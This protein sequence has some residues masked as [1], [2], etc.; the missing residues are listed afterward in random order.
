M[1][2]GVYTKFPSGVCEIVPYFGSCV[3]TTGISEV[4]V[5]SFGVITV[6]VFGST[7]IKFFGSVITG[8]VG[9]TGGSKEVDGVG[10]PVGLEDGVAEFVGVGLAEGVVVGLEDGDALGVTLEVG[11]DEGVGVELLDEL[12]EGEALAL[13]L[14]FF[15]VATHLQGVGVGS[16]EILAIGTGV[17]VADLVGVGVGD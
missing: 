6:G 2:V 3:I 16:G 9:R 8:G 1:L 5:I 12:D 7:K 10:E 4:P 17:G 14:L 15:K 11:L 13:G